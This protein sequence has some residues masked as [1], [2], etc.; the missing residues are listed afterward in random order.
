[1]SKKILSIII[2]TW[3]TSD[4]TIK[5][6]DSI[7]KYLPNDYAEIIVVDNGSTDN[8]P[9]IFS[10]LKNINYYRLEKNLGY[11][12]AC[13][14]GAN[15]STAPYLLFL[16]SDME[17]IDNSL[18]KMLDFYTITKNCGL[19][20]PKF[21][22][23]NKSV[24]SSVFP[25]QSFQNAFKE[26]FL[27]QSAYS[28]YTPASHKA[29]PVWAISGGAVLISKVIFN[30]VGGWDKRYFMYY[31]DMELCRQIRNHHLKVYYYPICRLIHRHG[32]SG[33]TLADSQNQWKRLIPG[34]IQYHGFIKH[35]FLNSLIWWSQ[36]LKIN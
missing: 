33:K 23:P 5:C 35:Y 11:G 14:F 31:E 21:L 19:I 10:E 32:A 22:N 20:G 28:K 36:K 7:I 2:P 8:T 15:K 25:D 6:V 30:K 18:I 26:F 17:F 12:Q 9:H 24:Q 34:S 1:M 27:K 16:N 4:I 13:N 29:V 3:N